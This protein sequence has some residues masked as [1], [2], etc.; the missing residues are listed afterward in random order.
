MFHG[1]A[2]LLVFMGAVRPYRR[3]LCRRAVSGRC[4]CGFAQLCQLPSFLLSTVVSTGISQLPGLG[5][6]RTR[7]V[8][9]ILQQILCP[10]SMLACS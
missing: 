8:V 5:V 2:V 4:I 3:L 9:N 10:L 7:E 1:A 6:V